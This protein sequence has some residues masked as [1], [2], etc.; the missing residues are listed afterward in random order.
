MALSDQYYCIQ[1]IGTTGT[2][3]LLLGVHA[4]WSNAY[5]PM[6][7]RSIFIVA[8]VSLWLC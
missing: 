4:M 5:N 6:K 2:I 7:D 3:N 1:T 8:L